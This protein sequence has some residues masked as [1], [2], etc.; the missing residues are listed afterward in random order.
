MK[1]TPPETIALKMDEL[2]QLLARLK[3]SGIEE[4]DYEMLQ[5]LVESYVYLTQAI[6]EKGTKIAELR[7][8]LFGAASEKTKQVL[9]EVLGKQGDTPSEE[10]AETHKAKPK[11][12][13]HGRNSSATYRGAQR[14][15]ITNRSLR[16]GDCCPKCPKGKVYKLK[17]PSRLVRLIGAAPI[18]AQIYELERLRCSL[19]GEIFTAD[20]PAG[21]GKEKYDATSAAMIALLRYGSGLP[22]NRLQRLQGSLGIPLPDATQW[23]IAKRS[24]R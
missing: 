24:A 13:G 19:C 20:A 9:E 14:T 17:K 12:K 8:L 2:E 22:F 3:A 18:Q 4:Q 15:K 10:A 23:D 16:S 1:S 11:R 6:E 5:A 21:V 7:R